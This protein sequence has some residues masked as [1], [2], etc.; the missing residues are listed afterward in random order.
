[1]TTPPPWLPA[2]S[3]RAL[4]AARDHARAAGTPL[5][6]L[7]AQL[8]ALARALHPALPAPMLREAAAAVLPPRR[9]A[10][11]RSAAQKEGRQ[12][13]EVAARVIQ[14]GFTSGR[15]RAR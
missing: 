14:G 3:L 11:P 15:R 1:M 10:S 13:V 12:P 2:A 9:P 4:C 7:A 8:S 6:A 5:P